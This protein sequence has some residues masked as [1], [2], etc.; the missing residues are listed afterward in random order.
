MAKQVYYVSDMK[1]PA[2]V[3]RLEA[4]E[5]SLPGIHRVTASYRHQRIEVEYDEHQFRDQEI[6]NLIEE[7]GYTLSP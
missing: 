7:T 5:D 1:C 6:R 3:M 4:I 2:C